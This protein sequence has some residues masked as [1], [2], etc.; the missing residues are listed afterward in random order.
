MLSH[1][2]GITWKGASCAHGSTI[3]HPAVIPITEHTTCGFAR[4]DLAPAQLP[5][6]ARTQQMNS[7]MTA[8]KRTSCVPQRR[9]IKVLP[10]SSFINRGDTNADVDR[11]YVRTS[12]ALHVTLSS[13]TC[14]G[15]RSPLW[16]GNWRFSSG[17]VCVAAVRGSAPAGTCSYNMFS[18]QPSDHRHLSALH[19]FKSWSIV[20]DEPAINMF[21]M[22]GL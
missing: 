18:A 16:I 4:S 15:K 5:L 2:I 20:S 1:N 21:S 11:T 10:A 17:R 6:L 13:L 22:K 7:M 9:S 19:G 12:A 8:L 3:P 14:A